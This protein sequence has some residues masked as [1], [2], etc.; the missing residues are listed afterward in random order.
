[1]R[2]SLRRSFHDESSLVEVATALHFAAD[3]SISG[4]DGITQDEDL[5]IG[6][7]DPNP[8]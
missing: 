5:C 2:V 6:D 4:M 3:D 8:I 7:H 1:V